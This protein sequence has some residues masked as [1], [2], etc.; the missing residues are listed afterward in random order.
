MRFFLFILLTISLYGES[1]NSLIQKGFNNNPIIQS[2]LIEADLKDFD[3][4]N[5]KLYKNP[6]I[7]LGINDINFD[8]PEK[9]DL[10]AMQTNYISISQQITNSDKL[11]YKTLLSKTDKKITLL[12]LKEEKNKLIRNI[13]QYY[14]RYLQLKKQIQLTKEKITNIEKINSYHTNHI[15]HKKAFQDILNNDLFTDKLNLQ[16]LLDNEKQK[17]ILIELSKLT[18]EEITTLSKSKYNLNNIS[19]SINNH[20]LLLIAN[21]KIEKNNY[22]KSLAKENQSSDYTISI[23]YYNRDSFDD[24]A[25]IALKIPLNIY[26]KEKNDLSKAHKSIDIAQQRFNE[27]NLKLKRDFKINSSKLNLAQNSLVLIKNINGHLVK[28]KE[29]ISNKN[30]LDSI[31]EILKIE[32]KLLDNKILKSQYTKDIQLAKLE[33]IYLTSSLQGLH[34]E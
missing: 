4:A 11:H 20:P 6:T 28:E 15:Q 13:Y 26:G 23:G 10:E 19:N 27:V 30:S 12:K 14:F 1:L 16:I 33:L 18:N 21:S 34:N 17:Q 31:V 24:Y 8:D 2:L 7:T 29:L 22:L 9:R 32:N 5:S 3:I 25:N